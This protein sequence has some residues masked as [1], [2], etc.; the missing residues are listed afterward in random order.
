MKDFD[1]IE[2][3][4][5]IRKAKLRKEDW[6]VQFQGYFSTLVFVQLNLCPKWSNLSSKFYFLFT[7]SFL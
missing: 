1:K 3:E 5:V 6:F 4:L 2:E 7:Y